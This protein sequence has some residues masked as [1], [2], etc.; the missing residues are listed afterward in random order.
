MG[1]RFA[2]NPDTGEI[3]KQDLLTGEWATATSEEITAAGSNP[4][5]AAL[6]TAGETLSGIKDLTAMMLPSPDSF[7][8]PNR[9]AGS[10]ALTA[11][12]AQN[13]QAL[14]EE[15]PKATTL[16]DFLPDIAAGP[17]A[18]TRGAA[19]R[20]VARELADDVD[21]PL[22]DG[23]VASV[24][25]AA[26]PSP[27]PGGGPGIIRRMG[28]VADA[29]FA[30]V[31]K[32]AR[33]SGQNVGR[34]FGARSVGAGEAEEVTEFTGLERLFFELLAP[35]RLTPDQ[36]TLIDSG[37][38]AR[39]G[40]RLFPGQ[41]RGI[42]MLK[43]AAESDPIMGRAV[44]E[45]QDANQEILE[46]LAL[47]ALRQ[48]TARGF[49]RGA[50]ANHR[51]DMFQMQREVAD[52]IG[53]IEQPPKDIIDQISRV[54]PMKD[55]EDLGFVTIKG[56]G[57]QE[58]AEEA[59]EQILTMSGQQIMDLRRTLFALLDQVTSPGQRDAIKARR[60]MRTFDN[61]DEWITEV[62]PK[63]TRKQWEEAREAGRWQ[64]LMDKPGVITSDGGIS[65]PKLANVLDREMP[66]EFKRQL[67]AT[68]P[69]G[70]KGMGK[71]SNDFIDAIQFLRHFQTNIGDSGTAT[72]QSL[73]E[74]VSNPKSLAGR[75]AARDFLEGVAE[76][77]DPAALP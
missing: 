64:I 36:Q 23:P 71:A 16:G 24:R 2:H 69:G 43:A 42:Q 51:A 45:I 21:I 7:G 67:L 31:R 70:R 19:S 39:L 15:F 49:S 54:L 18:F 47:K 28:V 46:E 73:R 52:A 41:D 22:L 8:Q 11:L 32:V 74:A 53:T 9:E 58:A 1:Q 76:T 20:R 35:R 68:G 63:A 60:I 25:S 30:P 5:E 12:T 62:I 40:L 50:V 65:F 55:L 61:F 37:I 14:R 34:S 72:R 29:A 3:L 26:E 66:E 27:K 77:L 75:L 33:E 56:E 44:F 4:L 17:L 6:I 59:G 13:T 38:A 10:R 48:P 57:A